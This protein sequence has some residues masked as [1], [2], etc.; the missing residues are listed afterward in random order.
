MLTSRKYIQIT[1]VEGTHFFTAK[2]H[3]SQIKIF[4]VENFDHIDQIIRQKFE[5]F[6]PEPPARVWENV[7]S[8]ISNTPPPA[9]SGLMLPILFVVTFLLFIGS[10]V[11][12]LITGINEEVPEFDGTSGRI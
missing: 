4:S 7:R 9:P 12:N 6:E 10:L 8:K 5:N 11:F 1:A 3:A 2:A